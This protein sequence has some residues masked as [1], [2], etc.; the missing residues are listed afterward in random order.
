MLGIDIALLAAGGALLVVAVAFIGGRIGARGEARRRRLQ[1]QRNAEREQ[2]RLE[3]R[4][5]VCGAAID[6]AEDIF[7]AGQWWH[8][9]CYRE[10]VR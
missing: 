7:E 10:A 5:T 6:P 2:Q 1:G 8:R 9:A 4:C 3:E